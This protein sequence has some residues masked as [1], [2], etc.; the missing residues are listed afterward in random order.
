[1]ETPKRNYIQIALKGTAWSYVSFYG[2]KGLVFISTI[3]LARVLNQSDFGVASYALTILGFFDIF[4]GFGLDFALIYVDDDRDFTSTAFWLNLGISF[5]LFAGVWIVGSNA[6]LIFNDPRAV[7]VTHALAF[8]FPL[9][10]LC[11]IQNA[12]M[13]REFTYGKKFI[14]EMTQYL[15][16]G[17]LSIIFALLGYSY[18]SLIIGQLGGIALSVIAYW[19]IMSWRPSFTFSRDK[20]RIMFRFSREIVINKV[21]SA[22]QYNFPNLFIGRVYGAASL[23]TYTTSKRVG[24]MVLKE[25]ASVTSR[26]TYPIFARLRDDQNHLERGFLLTL[27]YTVLILMPIGIGLILVAEPFV[28]LF[29]TDK[30]LSAV[31]IIQIMGAVS[32]IQAWVYNSGDLLQAIGKTRTLY[33]ISFGYAVAGILACF[34]VYFRTGTLIDLAYLFLLIEMIGIIVEWFFVSKYLSMD[35]RKILSL[36]P[37]AIVSAALMAAAVLFVQSL[38]ID[39]PIVWQLVIPVI[40]GALV[41]LGSLFLLFKSIWIETIALLKKGIKPKPVDPEKEEPTCSE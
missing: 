40:I 41:Y 39:W 37:P 22:L 32:M 19:L 12:L 35:F 11:M 4:R 18:W 2:A 15:G 25:S 1:M 27:K 21:F 31:P 14:P 29:L 26:V 17:V 13:K 23:G 34:L 38:I 36:F 8:Y 5:I 6:E 16:K 28:R 10:A 20:A 33:R 30:W 3:I 24:E 9:D 7:S